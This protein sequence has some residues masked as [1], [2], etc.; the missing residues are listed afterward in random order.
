M[1]LALMQEK[2]LVS[3]IVPLKTKFS[4]FESFSDAMDNERGI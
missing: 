1:N 4:L 3:S 2:R